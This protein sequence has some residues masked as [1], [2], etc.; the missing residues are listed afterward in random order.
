VAKDGPNNKLLPEHQRIIADAYHSFQPTSGFSSVVT[1]Q[2]IK[3]AGY[4][5]S[6]NQYVARSGITCMAN[7]S[8]LAAACTKFNIDAIDFWEKANDIEKMMDAILE[9]GTKNE[10]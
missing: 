3:K 6:V 7:D 5:L 2:D 4:S 10:K 8:T 9:H 1:V